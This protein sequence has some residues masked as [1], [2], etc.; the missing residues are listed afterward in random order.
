MLRNVGSAVEITRDNVSGK[1]PCPCGNESH[2]RF[3]YDNIYSMCRRAVHPTD[4][5]AFPDQVN[6]VPI[7]AGS[8]VIRNNLIPLEDGSSNVHEPPLCNPMA[9]EGDVGCCEE[10]MPLD[11]DME[12][13]LSV[14][15]DQSDSITCRQSSTS[16]SLDGQQPSAVRMVSCTG[17]SGSYQSAPFSDCENQI[18]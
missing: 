8:L 10:N 3:S 6:G 14:T 2:A 13:E 18:V 7:M 15:P 12:T 1:L 9:S 4:P 11:M 5:H 16:A 17:S